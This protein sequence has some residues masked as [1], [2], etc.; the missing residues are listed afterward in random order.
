MSQPKSDVEAEAIMLQLGITK[1][2]LL[3]SVFINRLGNET[4]SAA[5]KSTEA[6]STK[7]A[8]LQSWYGL[9]LGVA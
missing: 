5:D 7:L 6:L 1:T 2:P 9:K 4:S 3:Q 8:E